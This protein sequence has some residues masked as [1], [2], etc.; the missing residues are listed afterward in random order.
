[1]IRD[2]GSELNLRR[3]TIGAALSLAQSCIILIRHAE[4]SSQAPDAALTPRGVQQAETLAERLSELGIDG[5]FS[6]PY[7]RAT[8]TI[9]PFSSRVGIPVTILDDLRERVLSPSPL[10]DWLDHIARSFDDHDYK[11]P[12]GESLREVRVRALHAMET[13]ANAGHGLAAIASHGNLIASV[14]NGIDQEFGF[15]QWR[16]LKNPELFELTLQNGRP[17]AYARLD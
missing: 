10:P 4:S 16:A 1:M 15:H 14:L 5:L 8:A 7:S 11:L 3:H 17:G 6:S 12:G 9:S 2:D 13:I